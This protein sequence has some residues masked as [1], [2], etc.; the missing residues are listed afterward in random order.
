MTTFAKRITAARKEKKLTQEQVAQAVGVSRQTVS[1]WENGR[2]EPTQEQRE[3]AMRQGYARLKAQFAAVQAVYPQAELSRALED[4][5][6]LRLVTHGVDAKSA[7]ELTHLRE[8][9]AEAMAY[10]A[11]RARE[12][13]T[14]AMQAG[15]LRPRESG[16]TPGAG[17]AFAESP[18]HW[19][20]QT[21]EELKTRARRGETI[22]L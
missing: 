3:A 9:T 17:G 13:L 21:R 22:R 4:P 1:H 14:A 18:E 2:I 15:Y 5:R 16:L 12:E 19:S 8:L 20:R 11:R 10:G 6:F 7:Y